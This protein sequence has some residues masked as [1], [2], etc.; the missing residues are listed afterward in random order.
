MRDFHGL[1]SA[2]E[3]MDGLWRTRALAA[4]NQPIAFRITRIPETLRGLG[5]E[6]PETLRPPRCS[7]ERLPILVMTD[8][9]L[10]PVIHACTTQL[11]VVDFKA[12]RMHQMEHTARDR[13]HTANVTR[14][15]GNLRMEQDEMKRRLHRR[16]LMAREISRLASRSLMS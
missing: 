15:R 7:Q 9:Q 12:Q 13:T 14:V 1:R 3:F 11:G 10:M 2:D 5:R 8:V 4:E 6:E 16:R